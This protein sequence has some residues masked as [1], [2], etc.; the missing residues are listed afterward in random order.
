MKCLGGDLHITVSTYCRHAFNW[1]ALPAVRED[2]D[3]NKIYV[4]MLMLYTKCYEEILNCVVEERKMIQLLGTH[5]G[6][7]MLTW[8]SNVVPK[9]TTRVVVPTNRKNVPV[10]NFVDAVL[11]HRASVAVSAVNVSVSP[12]P[13]L[14]KNLSSPTGSTKPK[15]LPAISSN[16]VSAKV[17]SAKPRNSHILIGASTE[18]SGVVLTTSAKQLTAA[19]DKTWRREG[20][21]NDKYDKVTRRTVV[22]APTVV[23]PNVTI[24]TNVAA[25][26][27][28]KQGIGSTSRAKQASILVS[29]VTNKTRL[30][31]DT[32]TVGT[33]APTVSKAP[34]T[35]LPSLETAS[36]TK[37][38][39]NLRTRRP[40]SGAKSKEHKL[41]KKL[42]ILMQQGSLVS[43][44]ASRGGTPDVGPGRRS[45][46]SRVPVSSMHGTKMTRRSQTSSGK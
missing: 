17:I 9:V 11:E 34:S 12:S 27:V 33:A 41:A 43:E 28:G 21:S 40:T 10:E 22:S 38:N 1:P 44:T 8:Q 7:N 26:N 46:I 29:K 25:L 16:A 35:L 14:G 39:G 6:K 30:R 13:I 24:D 23:K 19:A 31:A 18:A 32:M 36:S 2:S 3:R 5:R 20:A 42:S 4:A 45:V 15:P 37:S